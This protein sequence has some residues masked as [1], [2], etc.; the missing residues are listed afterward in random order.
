MRNRALQRGWTLNEYRNSRRI[1][2]GR[3][4]T[5][6]RDKPKKRGSEDPGLFGKR[7]NCIARSISITSRRSC[8]RTAA[9]SR[10]PR[11]GTLPRLIEAENLRGTF[12]CHTTASD[13]HNSLEE[14]AAAAQELGLQ[15]LGIADHS[16]SSIQA[17]GL[18]AARLR[19]QVA[20][21]RKLNRDLRKLPALCRRRVRYSPRRLARFSP[22]RSWPN[23]ITSSPPSTPLSLFRKRT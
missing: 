22:T 16:R 23:S 8:A 12:H 14:M 1:A 18:D 13:G 5:P 2:A 6:Q 19:V 4:R 21:I 3:A 17:R 15:Y 7:R 9:N 11:R 10:R 20:A